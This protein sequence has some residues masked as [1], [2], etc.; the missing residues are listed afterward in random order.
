MV[1]QL[2]AFQNNEKESSKPETY[3]EAVD[4][5]YKSMH[6]DSLA[7]LKKMPLY[8]ARRSVQNHR[9][10]FDFAVKTPAMAESCYIANE[11]KG[12]HFEDRAGFILQ[13][14]WKKMNPDYIDFDKLTLAESFDTTLEILRKKSTNRTVDIASLPNWIFDD[15]IF[16]WYAE[17]NDTLSN[18]AEKILLNNSANAPVAALYLAHAKFDS[19]ILK[20]WLEK[21]YP[22]KAMAIALP[23]YLPNNKETYKWKDLSFQQLAIHCYGIIYEKNFRDVKDYKKFLKYCNKNYLAYWRYLDVPNEADYKELMNDP[24]KLI[25]IFILSRGYYGVNHHNDQ[26]IYHSGYNTVNLVNYIESIDAISSEHPYPDCFRKYEYH[27]LE[28]TEN[29][30]PINALKYVADKIPIEKLIAMLEPQARKKYNKTLKTDDF[31][32]YDSVSAFLIATQYKRLLT[33]PDKERIFNLFWYYWDEEFITWPM[34]YFIGELLIQADKIKAL[35][36]FEKYFNGEI[37]NDSFTRQAIL[38]AFIKY[39]FSN[40]RELIES[41]Y[42]KIKDV[43]LNH[44]PSEQETILTYLKQTDENTLLLYNKIISDPRFKE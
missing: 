4:Y 13:G 27:T 23:E 35:K 11:K 14:V 15:V 40:Q 28:E 9:N 6:K 1:L 41:W 5:I 18:E 42:W 44:S 7:R 19:E 17:K 31:E 30:K 33:Y 32:D 25:E 26:L 34:Q 36:I 12:V 39:D 38:K 24:G 8:L 43:D 20:V 21:N 10:L 16:Y 22:N 3:E 37:D 29:R 2:H